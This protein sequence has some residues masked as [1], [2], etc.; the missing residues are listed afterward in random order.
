MGHLASAAF[1][2]FFS[3]A[4]C[5]RAACASLVAWLTACCA[6]RRCSTGS[7]AIARVIKSFSA[8]MALPWSRLLLTNVPIPSARL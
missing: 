2:F 3:C 6:T 8:A 7:I 4:A 1:F 5:A